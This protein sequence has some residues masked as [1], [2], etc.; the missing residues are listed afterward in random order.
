MGEEIK[1]GTIYLLDEIVKQKKVK[2]GDT[3]RTMGRLK[4]IVN[5]S[6]A[7][8]TYKD[9]DLTIH[10]LTL[11]DSYQNLTI[12]STFQFIG[13]MYMKNNKVLLQARVV[14]NVDGM[15]FDLFE[16]ALALMRSKV[17]NTQM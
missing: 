1:H 7:I 2:D 15:D 5:N 3:V 12:G 11:G 9:V 16:K 17:L 14:R 13:E 4:Q 6:E 8:I 10:T